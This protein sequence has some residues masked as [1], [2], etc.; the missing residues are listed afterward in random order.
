MTLNTSQPTVSLPSSAIVA[1]FVFNDV[2]R[3]LFF[4]FL[5]SSE[6]KYN[7][8]QFMKIMKNK[9]GGNRSKCRR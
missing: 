8:G 4:F 7:Q 9:N 1:H 6:I 2:S 5:F 3:P